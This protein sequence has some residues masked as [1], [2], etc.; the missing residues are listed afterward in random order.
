LEFALA[1]LNVRIHDVSRDKLN[2]AMSNIGKDLSMLVD[3]GLITQSES[4][5]AAQRILP[6]VTL[7]EA[8][9]ADLVV[10]AVF[11]NLQIKQS[12]FSRLDEICPPRTILASNTSTLLPSSL[13]SATQRPD[14]VLVTHYFNP[15]YLL[16]LVE[17][18][19]G[20]ETSDET[21]TT[22]IEFLKKIGK[23]PALVQKEVPGFI[24][25]RLQIAL[26]REALALVEEG[27]ASPADVDVVIKN[28]FGRRLSAA[29]VFEVFELAGWDLIQEIA[30]N[31]LPSISSSR[32]V[33][34]LLN[35][36][37]RKGELGTK[38]GKGF[39]SWN[40]ES[41]EALR[42]RIADRLIQIQ[43]SSQNKMLQ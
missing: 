43:K 34:P 38:T 36:M 13:A 10:E 37:V 42:L 26:L 5:E 27:V 2:I 8:V 22:I 41:A 32:Q 30:G 29:G 31:L 21:I 15:P 40:P 11:E 20:K 1:G 9:D 24:G 23:A 12:I 33:S 19:R 17:V 7:E 14:K 25:N 18:V 28:S 39:Y 3:A 35:D 4:G 16:P 6:I